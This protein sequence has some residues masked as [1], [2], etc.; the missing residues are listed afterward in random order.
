MRVRRR[1]SE[2][3]RSGDPGW[4]L[5]CRILGQDPLL[6]SLQWGARLDSQLLHEHLPCLLVR[7]E[8]LRLPVGAVEGKHQLGAK[9]LSQRVFTDQHLQ[10]AE[11]VLVPP[12]RKIAI[13]PIHQRRQPQLVKLRHLVAPVRFEQQPG[14]GRAAPE[15]ERL[16]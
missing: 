7:V 9:T 6:Q 10:L 3:V 14:E 15:R 12:E 11:R 2:S 4:Q 16:P 8:R 5:E 13:D 1:S